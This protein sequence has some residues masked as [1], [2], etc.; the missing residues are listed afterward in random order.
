MLTSR[1]TYILICHLVMMVRLKTFVEEI[2]EL[3][4]L[5]LYLHTQVILAER[6]ALW[7]IT[8]FV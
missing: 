5:Y 2:C 1:S 7:D 6:Y 3:L 4:I 8:L